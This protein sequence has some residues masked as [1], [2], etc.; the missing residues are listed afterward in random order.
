[1]LITSNGK[2]ILGNVNVVVGRQFEK[3]NSSLSV[4]VC[5]SNTRVLKLSNII[6]RNCNNF[7]ITPSRSAW[8]VCVHISGIKVVK[9]VWIFPAKA[10]N[11]TSQVLVSSNLKT[12]PFTSLS[13]LRQGNVTKCETH[14]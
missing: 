1:M 12:S 7:A 5:V 6:S 11:P 9:A 4:A 13:G 2:K 3:E 10:E 8:K 14:V